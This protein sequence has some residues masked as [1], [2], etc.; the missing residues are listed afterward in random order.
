MGG[1]GGKTS[2][3]QS[4]RGAGTIGLGVWGAIPWATLT[5][6]ASHSSIG[7]TSYTDIEGT[8]RLARGRLEF[9]GRLGTRVGSTGGGHGI[10][11]E[12]ALTYALTR[13]LAMTLGAGRYPTDPTRGTIAGRYVTIGMRIGTHHVL[14]D[15]HRGATGVEVEPGEL[16]VHVAGAARVEIMADFTDWQPVVL[17][18]V[19]GDAWQVAVQIP[20]GP[21]LV[22]IRVD[23]G[24]WMAPAGVTTVKD[25]FGGEAGLIVVP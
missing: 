1:T 6:T 15:H 2:F 21:H 22:E 4:D 18:A 13:L 7:D 20:A 25:E 19:G 14:L 12:A 16:R 23:G 10:Y 17:T 8:S 9:D 24:P 5:V 3:G 11:G